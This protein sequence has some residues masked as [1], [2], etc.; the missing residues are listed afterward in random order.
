MKIIKILISS[1]L[2]LFFSFLIYGI[3]SINDIKHRMGESE[4]I[5]TLNKLESDK[6]HNEIVLS[7]FVN[8]NSKS[9]AEDDYELVARWLKDRLGSGDAPYFY[10]FASYD[11]WDRKS[12]YSFKHALKYFV[13]GKI[14]Y[15]IDAAR[16]NY[17]ESLKAVRYY[18]RELFNGFADA[19]HFHKENHE[20][21]F[22][23][24]LDKEEELKDRPVANW[25]CSEGVNKF[26]GQYTQLSYEEWQS[27]R[28]E[29]R[30]QLKVEMQA[31][32]DSKNISQPK[33]SNPLKKAVTFTSF[34]ALG[35]LPG[36]EFQSSANAVSSDG[37]IVVGYSG[38]E[39]GLEAFRWENGVMTALG[40]LP[41]GEN[42][43]YASGVSADGSVVVGFSKSENGQE[44]FRWEDGTISAIGD[45][46][47][48]STASSAL[49]VS[50]DGS[51]IV[52]WSKNERG[53][54]KAFIYKNNSI[55]RLG[56]ISSGFYTSSVVDVSEK[57]DVIVGTGITQRGGDSFIYKNN[58]LNSIGDLRGGNYLSNAKS[59]SADG[60]V[61]VG[62]SN[63][64]RGQEAFRWKN[65]IMQGLGDIEG[66]H[67][68]STATDVTADGSIVIGTGSSAK[69]EEAMIWLESS[70]KMQAISDLLN[71][72]GFDLE[73][74]GWKALISAKAISDDGT[75]IV[76]SGSRNGNLEAWIAKLKYTQN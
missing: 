33:K 40:D 57:G 31:Q 68:N 39:N 55:T 74:L 18:E 50:S 3:Y 70:N 26:K 67:F 45:L 46:N 48:N 15:R 43:S 20:Y 27:R 21:L 29:I 56:N 32:S 6:N 66:G 7:L 59:L 34:N 76:G 11:S 30:E 62:H 36:G 1:F 63:S 73:S 23:W 10:F 5:Q 72:D 71:Q 25:I 22:N 24:A 52:G 42:Y 17:P 35:D 65:N 54:S 28:M 44:A 2:F 8:F 64:S 69:G 16:C 47:I 13:A 12:K 60:S 53:N 19:L 49:S 38:S 14:I 75:T 51:V 9:L 41:G 4:Y 58:T 61:V 37:S